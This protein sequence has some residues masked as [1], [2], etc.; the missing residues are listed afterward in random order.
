MSQYNPLKRSLLPFLMCEGHLLTCFTV[1]VLLNIVFSIILP[2]TKPLYTV[3]DIINSINSCNKTLL[4]VSHCHFGIYLTY[5]TL[6]QKTVAHISGQPVI[7]KSW[8]LQF[9]NNDILRYY[10]KSRIKTY[11]LKMWGEKNPTR[12]CFHTFQIWSQT[13][14]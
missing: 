4:K 8:I 9:R 14:I 11:F 6:L 2:T 3:T 1:H 10:K 13:L 12:N 7:W 5:R